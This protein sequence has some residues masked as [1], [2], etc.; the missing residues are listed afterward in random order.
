MQIPAIRIAR[1]LG[2]KVIAVDGDSSAPGLKESDLALVC[3]VLDRDL[4]LSNWF[5]KNHK[6]ENIK[7]VF[8]GADFAVTT[9]RLNQIA[10]FKGIDEEVALRSK[11]KWLMKQAWVRDGVATPRAVVRRT[12]K[13]LK[14]G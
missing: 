2:L 8:P 11:N 6:K 7:A 1:D 13:E 3:D 9:A 10:G 14:D 4:G 12:I 5:K